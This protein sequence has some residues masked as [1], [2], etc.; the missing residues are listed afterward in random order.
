MIYE[1]KSF[2]VWTV[3]RTVFIIALVIHLLLGL[4]GSVLILL[5]V[6]ALNSV[7]DEPDVYYEDYPADNSR[8]PLLVIFIFVISIGL[9][10]GYMILS[11]VVTLIY[12][13]ISG[14]I[15][16]IEVDL[17]ELSQL[18]KTKLLPKIS[19]DTEEEE[20]LS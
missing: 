13:K 7:W 14:L 6:S 11:A 16:G 2:D 4:T 1:I 20:A 19:K 15:G 10:I 9:S 12:N 3:A 8:I 18:K 5:G 17:N